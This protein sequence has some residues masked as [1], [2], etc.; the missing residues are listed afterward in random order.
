MLS[1]GMERVRGRVFNIQRY[2]MHDG[3]GIRTIVFLKGCVLR[4]KW[5]ANPE[6]LQPAAQLRLF[7]NR[8]VQCGRCV[9]VCPAGAVTA[10]DGKPAMDWKACI[11]CGK[12]MEA[13][14]MN[15]RETVGYEVYA[16]DV[17]DEIRRDFAFYRRSGGGITLS[18]GEALLQPEFAAA[19]LRL[20]REEGMTTTIETCGCVPWS[21]FEAVIPYTDTFYFDLK[22]M[23]S[24][25][26]RRLTGQGN[27]IILEN[28][29]RLAAK[30]A[31]IVFRTPVIPGLNDSE[32][33]ISATAGFAAALEAEGLELLPYHRYGAGKYA[34]L[35]MEY[36][37]P[38][39]EPPKEE[40]M[41]DLRMIVEEVFDRR[42]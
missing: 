36:A 34:Q 16:G 38:E 37:L 15:A 23:D 6:G 22:H 9:Q 40:R 8:C 17:V 31:R 41:R 29:R 18:G 39:L 26:H 2:N 32:A 5:C 28:A 27:E 24:R 10:V 42:E 19:V 3:D 12:C 21:A 1:S 7:E 4:C 35:G 30:G 14:T 20:S 13:C 11:S 33:N 25:E